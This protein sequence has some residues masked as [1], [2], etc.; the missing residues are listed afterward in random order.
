MRVLC[1]RHRPARST[2]TY[3]AHDCDASVVVCLQEGGACKQRVLLV[4]VGIVRARCLR[5]LTFADRHALPRESAF[6]TDAG[7]LGNDHITRDDPITVREFDTVP[8]NKILRGPA[9]RPTCANSMSC[10]LV[11][12]KKHSEFSV[13]S[14]P[15]VCSKGRGFSHCGFLTYCFFSII[16]PFKKTQ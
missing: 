12:L 11:V 9:I 13:W 5:D 14:V 1:F 4:G 16:R 8:R 7:A 3:N 2:S 15:L 6:I 10:I